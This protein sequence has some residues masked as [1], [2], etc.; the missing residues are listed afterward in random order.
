MTASNF[1]SLKKNRKNEFDRLSKDIEKI[2]NEGGRQSD[3]TFW[4][5]TVDKAGNG[6]AVI[7][8][9]PAPPGEDSPFVRLFSHGFKGPTG[10]W[11]VENSLT[12]LGQ[13]DPVSEY[14]RELWATEDKDLQAQVRLQKRRL[15][16]ISNIYVVQDSSNPEN[17][18]KVFKYR[19]GKKIWDKIEAAMYPKFEDEQAINPFDFWEGANFKLKIMK[20]DKYQNYDK[21]EFSAPS[22]L[23][24]DDKL[25]AIW[26]SEHS[27]QALVAPD[28][29]KSYEELKKQLDK[30]LNLSGDAPAPTRNAD[31]ATKRWE[32]AEAD[33]PARTPR[34]AAKKPAPA[35]S[36]EEDD[37]DAEFR[38]LMGD[39]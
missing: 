28:Q 17:E 10:Q 30:V 20:V 29:F 16:Y 34:V 3:A 35:A 6:Y 26:K 31:Q 12:T 1:A 7:R 32:E 5:P 24:D 8:F 9:L 15:S 38:R 37:D 21:S 2:N 18:G 27:L 13:K 39:K 36:S 14:N 4:T 11:Y 25:E 33:A 23:A 19:Y 22:Q